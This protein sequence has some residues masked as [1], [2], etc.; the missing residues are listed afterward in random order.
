MRSKKIRVFS[1]MSCLKETASL[2]GYNF[3]E[4]KPYLI[5]KT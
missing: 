3:L 4:E 2:K 1:S 5:Q